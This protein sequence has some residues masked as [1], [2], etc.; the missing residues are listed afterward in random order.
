MYYKYLINFEESDKKLYDAVRTEEM[1]N[2]L[3]IED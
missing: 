2:A 1:I 3:Y